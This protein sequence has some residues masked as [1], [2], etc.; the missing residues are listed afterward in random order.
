M[1][2]RGLLGLLVALVAAVPAAARAAVV[3]RLSGDVNRAYAVL[4]REG[5]RVSIARPFTLRSDAATVV[6]TCHRSRGA[7]CATDR[8]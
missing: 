4:H 8:W 2:R 6:R 3:P 1:R 5:F 7:G